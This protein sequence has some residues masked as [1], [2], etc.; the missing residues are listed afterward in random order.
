MADWVIEYLKKKK[1]LLP[2]KSKPVYGRIVGAIRT[3]NIKQA[4]ER[5]GY[6]AEIFPTQA[7]D[8]DVKI[9]I[10]DNLIAVAEV[11]NWQENSEYRPTNLYFFCPHEPISG[12]TKPSSSKPKKIILDTIPFFSIID[13]PILKRCHL[14]R[15]R[16][17]LKF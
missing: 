16:N 12:I 8:V 10:N 3:T 9:Y 6:I 1:H 4:L 7:N 17:G 2:I 5:L 14:V 11:T 13:L 15:L